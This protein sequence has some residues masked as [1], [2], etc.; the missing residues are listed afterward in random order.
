MTLK[1]TKLVVRMA[2]F[3]TAG[4]VL[5]GAVTMWVYTSYLTDNV[6]YTRPA[7]ETLNAVAALQF[8][9]SGDHDRAVELLE[10]QLDEGLLGLTIYVNGSADLA[11]KPP[12][13]QAAV[14]QAKAYRKIHPRHLE[15]RE[16]DEDVQ[17]LLEGR[18]KRGTDHHPSTCE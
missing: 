5:G 18:V 6:Y 2:L 17:E 13:V 10:W 3:F 14:A 12:V 7:L 1:T 11:T 15:T 9:R 8:V 16:L 4:L